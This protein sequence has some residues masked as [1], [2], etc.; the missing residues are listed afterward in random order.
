MVKPFSV[1]LLSAVAL[2]GCG[3]LRDSAVNPMNW[4]GRST[5]A[6]AVQ[7]TDT[8]VNPLIPARRESIFRSESDDSYQGTDVA[9]VTELLIERRPGGAIIRATGVAIYQNA[10]EVRLVKID[11]ESNESTLTYAL[12]ALQPVGPQGSANARL[13]TAAEWLT[14]NELAGIRTIQV[15]SRGNTRTVRR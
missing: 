15:K 10:F 12:R 14:D 13:L 1:L 8:E 9:E 11:A 6:P 5:S 3:G 4:F 2:S 7:H